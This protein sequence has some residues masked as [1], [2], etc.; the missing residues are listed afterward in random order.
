[1]NMSPWPVNAADANHTSASVSERLTPI[2]W[3][4]M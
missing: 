4:Y 3:A 1:M 2:P